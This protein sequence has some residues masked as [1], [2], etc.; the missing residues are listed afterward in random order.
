LDKKRQFKRQK[1]V[2]SGN[3]KCKKKLKMQAVE[4]VG[5]QKS[6]PAG[7]FV[8]WASISPHVG[9]F[10]FRLYIGIELEGV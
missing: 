9:F 7:I 8:N 4:T 6:R 2:I 10:A 3:Y 5:S 1:I